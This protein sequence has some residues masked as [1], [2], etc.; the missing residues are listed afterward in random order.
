M[1]KAQPVF[2]LVL[3][4]VVQ[5]LC[6]LPGGGQTPPPSG[7]TPPEPG[8]VTEPP[9]P[10]NERVGTI[11]QVVSQVQTGPPN[12]LQ[13]LNG[14]QDFHNGDGVRVT[15]GGKGKLSLND[16]TLLTL[17]NQAQV[18]GVNI[19]I[20][21]RE[22]RI[23]LDDEGFDGNVPSGGRTVV[24]MPNGAQFIVFGTN[25]FIQYN[26]VT[27]IATGG[28]YD[29][30]VH[31]IQAGGTEQVLPPGRM[32]D[33]P[34][35]GQVVFWE[36]PFKPE[37][38]EAAVDQYGTPTAGLEG[39]ILEFNMQPLR[40]QPQPITTIVTVPPVSQS[41]WSA[42]EQLDGEITEAP[43]IASWASGRLDVF[44]RGMDD[45]LWHKAWDGTAWSGWEYLGGVIT[46]SPAAVSWGPNRIDIFALGQDR[47]V[48]QFV[49]DGAWYG[50][51][52]QEGGGVD[53]G[54][55]LQDAPAV[56][57]GSSNQLDLFVRRED[58]N[59]RYK[60][61]NGSS[62]SL[63]DNLPGPIYSSPSAVSRN[64]AETSDLV[65]RGESGQVLW[66]HNFAPWVSL[67]Q[68]IQD[69]PAI[70][71]WGNNRLDVFARGLDDSLLHIYWDGFTWS[72]W[73]NLGGQIYSSPAAVSWGPGRIDVFARGKIGNLIHIWYQE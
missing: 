7:I 13:N 46:S 29:G 65:A 71:S 54:D 20:S 18:A 32:V 6:V 5:F 47:Q 42:W 28:N 69:A 45:A 31:F 58:H 1:K 53:F 26:T 57:S 68:N 61:W 70:A 40:E 36:I 39:L 14:L 21:P 62:W 52:P 9:Q 34:A 59:I 4:V 73:E 10:Q 41:R 38:F 24:D 12:S 48:W 37:Q 56:S 27:R 33:I 49:W 23:Q 63:W 17:Y 22:T 66:S 44:V 60:Y 11:N 50:W 15:D 43:A 25:F 8:I 30:T 3:L 64:A 35:Q 16:G 55:P 51:Y 2:G 67:G 19:S 72:N